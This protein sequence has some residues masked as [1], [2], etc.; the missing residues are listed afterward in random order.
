MIKIKKRISLEPFRNR[1][2]PTIRDGVNS[3]VNVD[4]N[5]CPIVPIDVSVASFLNDNPKF[6]EIDKSFIVFPIMFQQSLDDMGLFTNCDYEE[7][8]NLINSDPDPYKRLTALPLEN[9]YTQDS[10]EVTGITEAHLDRVTSY[11]ISNPYIEGFNLALLPSQ[12]FTGVLEIKT[13]SIVYVVGGDVST[14]GT[15]VVNTGVLFETF[16]ETRLVEDPITGEQVAIPL[17]TF[18]YYTQGHQSYNTKLYAIVHEDKYLGIVGVP[19]V[20]NDVLI[21]RGTVNVLERFL[22]MSEIDSTE[23]LKRYGQGF[24]NLTT[25]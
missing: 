15:Y 10:M 9:Y 16:V 21:D 11:N 4:E 13:D 2:Y 12:S 20:D 18:S 25:T 22:K 1:E 23:Q 17:T 6:G 19:R 7:A 24:F 3:T 14:G 8:I 5:G